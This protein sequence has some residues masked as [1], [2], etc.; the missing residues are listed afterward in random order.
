MVERHCFREEW[1]TLVTYL[2]RRVW[3]LLARKEGALKRA[4]IRPQRLGI[5]QADH[6][7]VNRET[8]FAER[9]PQR[10]EGAPE[11]RARLIVVRPEQRGKGLAALWP[12]CDRQVD[13]ERQRLVSI[14][15]QRRA[16]SLKAWR[17]KHVE[18]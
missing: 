6:V 3:V 7:A 17:A 4:S 13:E 15:A 1:H 2:I 12:P 11:D 8:A 16:S 18:G 9:R 10:R 5:A 14:H